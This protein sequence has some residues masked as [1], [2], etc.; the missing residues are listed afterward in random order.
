LVWL[1]AVVAVTSMT[2]TPADARRAKKSG[3]QRSK[4]VKYSPP[5][6]AIVVDANS[7]KVLHAA[8][9]DSPRHPASL[10]KIMTLYLLFE[11]LEAGNLK[12]SSEL[13]VSAYASAQAPSKLGLRPGQTI[14][15]DDA[16]RALVTK[17]AN[18]VAVVVAEALAD[19]EPGFARQMT[20]KA[21][22]LGMDHTIYRNASG[23]PN[24]SQITTARDQALLG[25]AIQDRFPKYYRYFGTPS[26]TFR[27]RA[28]RNHNKLLGSVA[29]VDGI[30]T[31][32]VQASGFNLV[33]SVRRGN[34]HLVAVVLGGRTGGAR[35]ARM[36]ELIAAHIDKCSPVRTALPITEKTSIQVAARDAEPPRASPAASSTPL[37]AARPSTSVQ[38]V[39][40]Q[41]D[42]PDPE[43]PRADPAATA[44][45][46]PADELRPI[47][48]K[49]VKV[50]SI[51]LSNTAIAGSKAPQASATASQKNAGRAGVPAPA[52]VPAA[53]ADIA[54]AAAP[55]ISTNSAAVAGTDTTPAPETPAPPVTIAALAA[56]PIPP[57]S[58]EPAADAKPQ[59]AVATVVQSESAPQPRPS[60]WMIQVGALE[61]LEAAQKRIEL[62]RSKAAKLL[63]HS[64]SYTETI[65]KGD[66]TLY[67]ARFAGLEKATAEAACKTLKRAEIV[68]FAI[69]N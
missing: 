56:P 2:V 42:A 14:A 44:A 50:R 51:A 10:T 36:R 12:L 47:P 63:T 52:P 58:P 62:V 66:Q 41:G 7:G 30:K 61:S 69:K 11:Q 38:E 22:A 4:V 45:I 16:I 9:P 64:S 21:R 59:S 33:S 18:D 17:S 48:V 68:C 20:R 3:H 1:A 49:T 19:S 67:R 53:P 57:A 43:P 37:P 40:E 5:F 25:R 34:R 8:N 27:G 60:G 24:D 32:Y 65:S 31:G 46:P 54:Q 55:Q 23:L 15:V 26:F 35:D 6:S 29:G 28:M 13:D 39:I